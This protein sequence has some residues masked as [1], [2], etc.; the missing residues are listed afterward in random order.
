MVG[1]LPYIGGKRNLAKQTRFVI[2]VTI[3]LAICSGPAFSQYNDAAYGIPPN[4]SVIRIPLGFINPLSGQVH[5]EIPLVSLPTRSADGPYVATMVYDTNYVL[6][7]NNTSSYAGSDGWRLQYGMANSGTFTFSSTSASC[8]DPGY[9]Y[10]EQW[11]YSN[12]TFTDVHGTSHT[13][14][15]NG[16]LIYNQCSNIQGQWDPNTGSPNNATGTAS[17]GSGYTFNVTSATGDNVNAEVWAPNGSVVSH[18]QSGGSGYTG[19]ANGNTGSGIYTTFPISFSSSFGACWFTQKTWYMYVTASDGSQQTYTFTCQ[20]QN[21]SEQGFPSGKLWMMSSL[22]LPDGTTYQFTYDTGTTGNH[23]GIMTS[24]TLPT[25]GSISLGHAYSGSQTW[26]P[27]LTSATFSGGTWNFTNTQTGSGNSVVRTATVIGPARYDA[28]LKKNVN[29]TTVFTS[30]SGGADTVQTVQRYSG[31][32]TL[33]STDSYAYTAPYGGG[34]LSSHTTTLNDTGQSAQVQYQYLNGNNCPFPTQK[35]EYDYGASSPTRTTKTSYSPNSGPPNGVRVS[36]VS[37]YAGSGT[38]SPVAQTN[39]TYDEYSASYCKNGVPM[40]TNITGALN[41]DDADYGSGYTARGN[42][43]S[44]SR[45]VSGSTYV[46]SHKCYDTLGNVTQVVDDI[47]NPTT[48]SYAEKW[49][50]T[51]CVASGTL[52]RGFA[53]TI[54]DAV[55]S[56]TQ[57][58]RFS[59]T[60]LSSAVANENDL[61]ANNAGM[62]YTYDFANRPLCVTYADGGQTCNMYFMT[63]SPP[64]STQTV[65]VTSGTSV[66]TKTILDGYGRVTETQLTTDP[67]GL[68]KTDTTYDAFG[69]V[70]TISNPNRSTSDST[71]GITSYYYDALGRPTSTAEPDGS[72]VSTSYAGNAITATDE[73]GNKRKTQTDGLGRLAIVW[74]DPSS[75]NYETD[76][77]YDPLDNLTSVTQKGGA[78]SGSWRVRTFTYDGLSRIVCAAN[79]E[80]QAVTCPSS[81]TGTIPTG[82]VAYTYDANSNL[83]TKKMPSPNQASNGT[84]T[85]TTTYTY[86][87]VNRLTGKTYTD[88]YGGNPPTAS[89]SYGYDGVALTGCNTTPPSL[90]DSHPKGLRTS[91][92]DGSGATSWNHD[93]MGRVLS[94]KRNI[95][96][97][98]QTT[99]YTYNLDGSLATLIY[100]STGKVITYTTAG[101]GLPT[102]AQD[103]AGGINYVQSANYAAPGQLTGMSNGA[104]ITV[105][106]AF[107][108]RLEPILLSATGASGTIFSDCFDFHLGVAITTPAP[109]SFSKST[110]GD[111]GNVYK[112]VNNRS[113]YSG[114]TQ[115]FMY[116]SL[117]RI[118]QAYSNDSTWGETFSPTATAPG[119]APST[120]GI[121]AWGNV[122]NRS[123]VTGKTHAETFSAT[124]NT[125]NQLGG[126]T[127]DAAGNL[128]YDGSTTYNYDGE[129]RLV[130]LNGYSYY[131]DGDG[132]RVVKTNGSSGTLYWRGPTGDA[133]SESSLSG[134]T[135][136]EY[137]FFGGQRVARRDIT[138]S[139][140]HY[141]FSNHLGSHAVVENSTGSSC[142][143]DIDYYPYGGVVNDYCAT[144]TQHYRFT[145]QESDTESG[146]DYFGA[147]HYTPSISRFMTADPDRETAANQLNPQSWNL[148]AYALNNPLRFV[149]LTGRM[150]TP[151][152]TVVPMPAGQEGWMIAGACEDGGGE[153]CTVQNWSTSSGGAFTETNCTAGSGIGTRTSKG[154]QWLQ[155]LINGITNDLRD[156]S[157]SVSQWASQ[158]RDPLCMAG[159][160]TAGAGIGAGV[161]GLAGTS[162]FSLGP[163]GIL[164]T[165]GGVQGGAF[166]G[167]TAGYAVGMVKCAKSTGGGGGGSGG[168]DTQHGSEMADKRN[169]TPEDQARIKTGDKLTQADGATVYVKGVG[170][171]KYDYMI[172][173]EEGQ[174]VTGYKGTTGDE[175]RRVAE[176]YGWH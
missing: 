114:R 105:S 129:N 174:M 116:D 171:G 63:A 125:N 97:Q 22:G 9:P 82:A 118:L 137:I 13:L 71:Y 40:L 151:V 94:E 100:P 123:G 156:A 86:D 175:L 50:D 89:V 69:R 7:N 155:N 29:D 77:A 62:T 6:F 169:I 113:G 109:C 124:V 134:A 57:T 141:Y 95:D 167:G 72:A 146:L 51:S 60:G 66:G 48:Y 161:G 24:M 8:P 98:T 5:L 18:L 172:V 162:G 164:T 148:Y 12:F 59:C 15:Y 103:V 121:D 2:V 37:V 31:T 25:A 16:N 55:G 111:N 139:V 107:N 102:A 52:T 99:S 159:S 176:K 39:Y 33:L 122:A 65:L 117:N 143:Q 43:T 152:G 27:Y 168:G 49:A 120:L 132:N 147:R 85:V 41:H 20:Q 54:T 92:C 56:R 78:G 106:N 104:S 140:V 93:L 96:G 11:Q 142:E 53:S 91:I 44:I 17:D 45:L 74:E 79:P 126:F 160:T 1:P 76:Y 128:H 21:I 158:P 88:T 70:A 112:I 81:P 23:M 28:I 61:G 67:G 10:G 58:T 131:Y 19:D 153:G 145:G 3:A 38:G 130:N 154:P 87:A 108:D 149:D 157:Q 83:K 115:N 119:V 165:E 127:Y 136:E 80:I 135:Q 47:G 133:I 84:A 68:D 34:C 46:T 163:V 150:C 14:T 166:V 32:S 36:S 4:A 101:A 144:V 35:Q 170:H 42:V 138:G 75:L 30:V 73:V 110:L 26:A 173:N 90:T 64:Y